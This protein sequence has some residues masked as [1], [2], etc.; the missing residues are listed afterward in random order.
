MAY[1]LNMPCPLA[2]LPFLCSFF[3]SCCCCCLLCRFHRRFLCTAFIMLYFF[4]PLFNPL[5]TAVVVACV[6]RKCLIFKSVLHFVAQLRVSFSLISLFF[7]VLFSLGT[8]IVS[9]LFALL[10]WRFG[11]WSLGF[12][13]LFRLA[14]GYLW[15]ICK[16]VG[17]YLRW[18]FVLAAAHV[19]HM[20]LCFSLVLSAWHGI[21]IRMWMWM[22]MWMWIWIWLGIW[23][24]IWA[25]EDM[26][27]VLGS[28]W[29]LFFLQRGQRQLAFDLC[30][31]T[32]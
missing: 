2:P 6:D 16:C 30:C 13:F 24:S 4:A 32:F 17:S 3:S 19:M 5:P 29:V 27:M 11:V 25:Y 14:V 20:Y 10:F 8:T 28:Q 9:L 7:C 12:W 23:M 26:D 15:D 21:W 22:C 18:G 31:Q 1:A